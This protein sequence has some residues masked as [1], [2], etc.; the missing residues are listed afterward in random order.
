MENLTKSEE[1]FL[2]IKKRKSIRND[3]EECIAEMSER[4]KLNLPK[5]HQ[6]QQVRSNS[7]PP[8]RSTF[9]KASS[10][11]G[12]IDGA[13]TSNN[14][15]SIIMN[16]SKR[17]RT[18]RENKD[19]LIM[20]GD[21]VEEMEEEE[22]EN[23]S[24]LMSK[25]N[26]QL[27][28]SDLD[29]D[30]GSSCTPTPTMRHHLSNPHNTRRINSET[31]LNE[32]Q[33]R[34]TGFMG[35]R[36]KR[37]CASTSE[38]SF[39]RHLDTEKSLFSPKNNQNSLSRQS[40]NSS[41]YGS[42]LSLNSTN[43]KLFYTNSPFYNG[44]T[45]F[46]GA[47]A[48]PKRENVNVQKIRKPVSMRPSSSLSNSS[49]HSA[50]SDSGAVLSNATR[51]V[52][53]IMSKFSSPSKDARR[54][55]NN[56][57]SILKI[58]S[59]TQNRKRFGEEDLTNRSVSVAQPTGP[60]GR[61]LINQQSSKSPINP[62]LAKPLQIPTMSQLLQLKRFQ[63]SAESIRQIAQK[64]DSILNKK[65]D[66]KLPATAVSSTAPVNSSSAVLPSNMIT[67]TPTTSSSSKFKI[68]SNITKNLLRNDKQSA[69]ENEILPPVNL[70]DIKFPEM[71]SVPKIDLPAFS[72]AT[73]S[74]TPSSTNKNSLFSQ[75]TTS[76]NAPQ[77][78]FNSGSKTTSNKKDDQPITNASKNVRGGD[79][80]HAFS[81]P[82]KLNVQNN[83]VKKL[84]NFQ[85]NNS[86]YQFQKPLPIQSDSANKIHD[87]KKGES[88]NYL[89][90]L[91]ILQGF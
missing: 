5:H 59:L 34:L 6:I 27:N 30:G 71:N 3:S 36:S 44:K 61:P 15:N 77:M 18:I 48:Y 13:A 78:N 67:S 26:S 29:I 81:M 66:Y 28:E 21:D 37:F 91:V 75:T 89:T 90:L 31:N 7:E 35:N 83:V 86:C 41:L 32:S 73:S 52:M 80:L 62:L 40:F 56:I 55:G 49:V 4:K 33:N 51:K 10:R 45:M 46:G 87:D 25:S 85:V 82:L 8:L 54:M 16:S 22:E 2:N 79:G 43:S 1:N 53:E 63:S 57:N 76:I 70:P 74:F 19:E 50:G 38:L 60:Y 24:N 20:D 68:K 65:L 17:L 69:Q 14:N 84:D 58:P 47:S 72:T 88:I 23:D 39:T 9:S 64:S 11:V 42:N 12:N